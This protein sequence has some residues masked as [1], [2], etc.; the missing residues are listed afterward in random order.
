MRQNTRKAIEVIKKPKDGAGFSRQKEDAQ[1]PPETPLFSIKRLNKV[2]KRSVDRFLSIQNAEGYWVFDLEADTTIPSE[3][4]LLQRFL[5]IQMTPDLKDRIAN[6]IRGRQLDNGGWPLFYDGDEDLSCTVKAYFALK[7][8][9][10]AV[11]AP[12]MTRAR[13][14]ILGLGGAARVNVFTRI[15]MALFGQIP[16]RTAPAMP[17]EI[18]L[19]PK[20]F[21]FHLHKISYWS[22]TVIVPL[23]ILY[24]RQPVCNLGPEE[25]IAELFQ[26]PAQNLRN[27]DRY[28][29]GDLAKSLLILLDRAL[30]VVRPFMP[31]RPA[32][33]AVKIAERWTLKRMGE[34]GLGAIFPAMANAVM[35]LKVLGYPG[36]HPDFVRGLQSIEDLMVTHGEETFCQPCV[37]PIWDTCLS[38]SALR[39]AGIPADHEAI[40]DAVGWLFK[41][42]I[43]SKGDWT[44]RASNL[45]PAGWAFQFENTYYPDVDDTP[46]VLMALQRARALD[47]A[48]YRNKMEKAVNWLVGMQSSDGGWG[49][50]DLDNNYLYLN[51]IPFADHGALLDPSTSDLTGRCLEL[52]SML[53]YGLEFPPVSKA[54][55]FLK[56]EQEECGAWFGRWGVNYVYGTWSVL[57]GLKQ[58]GEDMS[59]PYIRKTVAWLKSCQNPDNGWGESCN[60]YAGVSFAG[61][62]KSTVS[63]TAWALLGLMAAG[64]V[65]SSA[66]QRGIHYL[67]NAQDRQ[68]NWNEKLY[69]GTGFP[70]VFYLRYHG[71]CQYF[72]L[73]ALGEYRR[74]IT[75]DRTCQDKTALS[76][77]A[78]FCLT[79]LKK[80]R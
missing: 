10:D 40:T 41:K 22:R 21:F 1:S 56:K 52:L 8:L 49:A 58:V 70:M 78:P 80:K 29:S 23:L 14:L 6:Y 61:K 42:L 51:K 27:I 12:H 48:E 79:A 46:M 77:P 45:K 60:S 30:K 37:S 20:W 68:G 26:E 4:V 55:E 13:N 19:L 72:S 74:L 65:K 18:M 36:D 24:A 39:E 63:Q 32:R 33:K 69:T 11:D 15:T 73:W 47:K 75:G 50:F 62:G 64:E 17:V 34:G 38:L 54:L 44:Y 16:W 28:Q 59:Q 31:K 2:I 35:A 3:Y 76:G 67:L 66:V 5:G 57:K 53:G 71:Y 43:T 7:L 9:G 25:S